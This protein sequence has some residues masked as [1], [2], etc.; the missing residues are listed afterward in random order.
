MQYS[1]YM[2][3]SVYI[4]IHTY[5]LDIQFTFNDFNPDGQWMYMYKIKRQAVD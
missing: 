2:Y 3:M 5:I 4:N 1:V